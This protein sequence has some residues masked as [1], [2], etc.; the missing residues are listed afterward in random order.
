M[1][2][3]CFTRSFGFDEDIYTLGHRRYSVTLLRAHNTICGIECNVAWHLTMAASVTTGSLPSSAPGLRSRLAAHYRTPYRQRCSG[4]YSYLCSHCQAQFPEQREFSSFC[5]GKSQQI[6]SFG[7]DVEKSEPLYT[8]VE[9]YNAAAT[10][11]NSQQLLKKGIPEIQQEATPQG[12]R[13][14]AETRP[15][16]PH[17]DGSFQNTGPRILLM[18]VTFPQHTGKENVCSL[19]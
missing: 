15:H 16:T 5:R 1:A 8:A 11:E 19:I 13:V 2:S 14:M 18:G 4:P 3:V 12:R 7:E 9:M 6:T 10:L 17:P